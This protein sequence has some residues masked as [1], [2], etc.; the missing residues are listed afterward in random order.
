MSNSISESTLYLFADTISDPDVV[1]NHE[2]TEQLFKLVDNFRRG[3]I[4]ESILREQIAGRL[5]AARGYDDSAFD[6][7]DV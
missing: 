6:R 4:N 5:I 1:A 3:L 7:F 2:V